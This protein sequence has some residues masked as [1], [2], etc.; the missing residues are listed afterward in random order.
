MRRA[1]KR[2]YITSRRRRRRPLFFT[3]CRQ[4]KASAMPPADMPTIR[5]SQL[6]F[7]FRLRYQSQQRTYAGRRASFKRA[8]GVDCRF[9]MLTHIRPLPPL[10][11]AATARSAAEQ[12]TMPK[13]TRAG[14]GQKLRARCHFEAASDIAAGIRAPAGRRCAAPPMTIA[15][16]APLSGAGQRR[17]RRRVSRSPKAAFAAMLM[18]PYRPM[19][20]G[21]R[22]A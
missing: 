9:S 22:R 15:H 14:A 1:K 20:S 7:D 8:Y 19:I 12:A 2:A 3:P 21:R 17:R 13:R 6:P 16:A 5:E 10:R 11:A 18:S 4:A